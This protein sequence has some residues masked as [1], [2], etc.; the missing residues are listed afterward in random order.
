MSVIFICKHHTF[1][2]YQE[3]SNDDIALITTDEEKARGWCESFSPVVKSGDICEW[4]SYTQAKMD[5][6]YSERTD[7][8]SYSDYKYDVKFPSEKFTQNK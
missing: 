4:R 8:D 7:K 5:K 6:D 3:H 2:G 1:Y